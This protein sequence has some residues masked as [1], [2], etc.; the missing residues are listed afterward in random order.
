MPPT[1]RRT[2]AALTIV[3]AVSA[4]TPVNSTPTPTPTP[5]PTFACTPI[6]TGNPYDCDQ[7]EYNDLTAERARYDEAAALYAD[8]M[9]ETE[10]LLAANEPITD[11]LAAKL[12]EDYLD[13]VT[14][15]LAAYAD[16][17]VDAEG[18]RTIEWSRPRSRSN[19]GSDLAIE[20]CSS[21][22]DLII[23][24]GGQSVPEAY[25]RELVFFRDDSGL[26]LASSKVGEVESCD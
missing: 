9:I 26:K 14:S 17:D 6:F 10:N 15:S 12:T 2:I 18:H 13:E 21:P 23:S 16:A 20:V 3:V 24:V 7:T 5:V 1:L 25:I 4:C 19:K 8:V 11:E 22:G